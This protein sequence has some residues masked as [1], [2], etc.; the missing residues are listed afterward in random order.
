MQSNEAH[1][2][3]P[4]DVLE[5]TRVFEAPATL[6]FKLWSEPEHLTRWLPEGSVSLDCQVDFREGGRW[7]QTFGSPDQ[8]DHRHTIFGVYRQIAAP[9]RL[10]M[11][12]VN[13][14]DQVETLVT[15]T[16]RELGDGRT[17][18]RFRQEGFASRSERDGHDGGWR[19]S[20]DVLAAYLLRLDRIEVT[21]VGRP[22]H[23]G[24]AEDIIEAQRR[25]VEELERQSSMRGRE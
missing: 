22:R 19:S 7:L 15:L 10:S 20:F 21:P 13:D 11:T 8:P 6:L 18:M 2:Q 1:A 24:T 4:D 17:E 14:Y 25:H 12:Y 23:D 5:I 16:F 9:Y 3:A